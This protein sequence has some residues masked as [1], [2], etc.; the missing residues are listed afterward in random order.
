MPL[1]VMI[2]GIA[3]FLGSHLADAFLARG[4][5]VVGIDDLSG[6]DARHVNKDAHWLRADCRNLGIVS[7]Y[8]EFTR[9]HIVYHLACHP[10]EGLS[11]FSP[12]T[13]GGSV[14]QGS[15]AVFSAAAQHKVRRV[16]FASSMAR[17]GDQPGPFREDM[18]PRPVDPYG[19]AKVAAE[20]TLRVLA[21]THGIEHV[22]AVP[23]NIIGVRQRYT[24]PFRNVASIMLNRIL[25][26]KEVVIYGD[27]QQR[28]CFSPIED[29]IV[30]LVRMARAP[31][32]GQTIN[33]GPDGDGITILELAHMC[34]EA[35][36]SAYRKPI[37]YPDRPRE[38]KSALCSSDKARELLDF[39][40][41]GDLK[42]CLSGM[43]VSIWATPFEY[44]L[45][46]E[47]VNEKTPETWR[48]RKI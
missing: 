4:D 22:I 7:S 10:H 31:I 20:D 43:A 17:Y 34:H 33:I 41:R 25:S 6:G 8:M 27:G 13:I 45:P 24:D 44:H 42:R 47:I 40:P 9:P 36:H 21:R 2:T 5:R 48:E 1:V 30:P 23:H 38:V 26:G 15:V 35:A 16:V 32:D 14:Y 39:E 11:V 29:C 28:R 19:I 12:A 18:T 37:F 3:G 46:I